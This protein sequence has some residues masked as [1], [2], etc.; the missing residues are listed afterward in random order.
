MMFRC[1]CCGECCRHISGIEELREYCLPSGVCKN[2]KNNRCIIYD[3]R[4]LVCRVDD[5]Y[6][7]VMYKYMSLEEFYRVNTDA[8]NILKQMYDK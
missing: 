3:N 6:H 8:C 2:L 7:K 4:P 1:D 5:M